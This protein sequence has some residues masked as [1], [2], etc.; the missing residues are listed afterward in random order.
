MKNK[1]YYNEMKNKSYYNYTLIF[2]MLFSKFL[3]R[4]NQ[5]SKSLFETFERQKF[6]QFEILTYKDIE[7]KN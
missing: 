2:N 5:I 1:S 6:L 4:W 7:F 3:L